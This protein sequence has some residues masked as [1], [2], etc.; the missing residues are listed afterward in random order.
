M[1][2]F[3]DPLVLSSVHIQMKFI[4]QTKTNIEQYSLIRDTKYGY[5]LKRLQMTLNKNIH[6]LL[7]L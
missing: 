5:R 1:I 2:L 6:S 4:T 3:A 7:L